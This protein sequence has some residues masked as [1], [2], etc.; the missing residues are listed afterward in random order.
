[1]HISKLSIVYRLSMGGSQSQV[2]AYI[3]SRSSLPY[4]GKQLMVLFHKQTKV[5]QMCTAAQSN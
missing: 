1:M 3:A 2:E 5:R 4:V